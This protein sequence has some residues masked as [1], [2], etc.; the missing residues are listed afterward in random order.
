MNIFQIL[1][2]SKRPL[3]PCK[4]RNSSNLQSNFT[5][6][7][8]EVRALMI[9]KEDMEEKLEAAELEGRVPKGDVET[10]LRRVDE[11]NSEVNSLQDTM[12]AS[13]NGRCFNCCPHTELNSK[14][15]FFLLQ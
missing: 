13:S 1:K 4:V 7:K 2:S 10:W 14:V 11:V 3:R 12:A 15:F 8:K 5:A 9:Q 6:L